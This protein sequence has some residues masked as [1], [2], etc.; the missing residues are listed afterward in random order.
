MSDLTTVQKQRRAILLPWLLIPATAV[1]V[2]VTG[3]LSGTPGNYPF[4]YVAY[5]TEVGLLYLPLPL[6]LFYATGFALV[7]PRDTLPPLSIALFAAV[8]VASVWYFRVAWSFGQEHQGPTVVLLFIY[9]NVG[10]AVGLIA[11]GYRAL[12]QPTFSRSLWF[13]F[14]VVLWAATTA[15]PYFGEVL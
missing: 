9:I 13:H 15:F 7:I 14:F 6:L 12:R 1:G 3:I 10:A 5:S 2:F 11:L 4:A 8:V